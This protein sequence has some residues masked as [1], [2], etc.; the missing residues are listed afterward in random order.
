MGAREVQGM[1]ARKVKGVMH[2]QV[3]EARARRYTHVIAHVLATRSDCWGGALLHWR[4]RKGCRAQHIV[5]I[6]CVNAGALWHGRVTGQC[7]MGEEGRV[8]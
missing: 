5:I 4:A 6:L 8:K 3:H 7:S 2:A 1:S